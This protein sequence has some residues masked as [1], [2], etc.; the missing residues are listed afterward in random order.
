MNEDNI[1]EFVT[2]V[3]MG[4]DS[5]KNQIRAPRGLSERIGACGQNREGNI[6]QL[7][8]RSLR[9]WFLV[10]AVFDDDEALLNLIRP[11]NRSDIGV[12]AQRLENLLLSDKDISEYFQ[13]AFHRSQ[14]AK[15]RQSMSG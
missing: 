12:L 8:K 9:A 11:F 1:D 15:K 7:L 2:S 14:R 3:R 5:V 10:V 13:H 6:A 4:L